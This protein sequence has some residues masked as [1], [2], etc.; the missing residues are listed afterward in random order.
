MHL[1]DSLAVGYGL[2]D[3]L[4]SK[5]N[6]RFRVI[7]CAVYLVGSSF[8]Y[9]SARQTHCAVGP[10]G[11]RRTARLGTWGTEDCSEKCVID[12]MI[13][14]H[15]QVL[16]DRDTVLA[17]VFRGAKEDYGSAEIREV[18]RRRLLMKWRS[19]TTGA[20]S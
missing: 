7:A 3:W 5:L 15:Q 6:C 18:V 1:L 16:S 13:H 8:E 10:V 17:R 2:N 11:S 4:L 20:S 19:T 9:E 14:A 12:L